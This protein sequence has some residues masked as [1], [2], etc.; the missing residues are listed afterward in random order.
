MTK[1]LEQAMQRV[2]ELPED[3]QD[4]V[5]ALVLA[6]LESEGRWDKRFSE[7]QDALAELAA[8]AAELDEKGSNTPLE[9]D[10]SKNRA[11]LLGS[12]RPFTRRQQRF[13]SGPRRHSY[14][15]KK[16]PPTLVSDSSRSTTP[17]PFFQ[18]DRP[19]MESLGG[20][21]RRRLGLVLDGIPRTL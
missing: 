7:N 19:R 18:R 16:I 5:A 11:Q 14:D 17:N 21:A 4:A 10:R 1:L 8:E 2:A 6:E 13:R 12:G 9:F 15:L 20:S 3:E